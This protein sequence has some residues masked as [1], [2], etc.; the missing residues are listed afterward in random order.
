MAKKPRVA[1]TRNLGT[2][3]ERGYFGWLKQLLR[4]GSMKWRPAAQAFKDAEDGTITNP[5]TG[6]PNKAFRCA[7]CGKRFMKA[8]RK[9]GKGVVK[10][11]IIPVV[12]EG[13]T[14]SVCTDPE[15]NPKKHICF[16]DMAVNRMY[17]ELEGWQILCNGCNQDKG[18]KE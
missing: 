15:F 10:D 3:S 1:K 7:G 8:K 2:L 4:K 14:V 11:H 6:R 5:K 17:P 12:P 18:N 16:G 13:K 9:G